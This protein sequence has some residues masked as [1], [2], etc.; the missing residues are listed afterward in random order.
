M[1]FTELMSSVA[2]EQAIAERDGIKKA[3]EE[4]IPFPFE[5]LEQ[6]LKS[7]VDFIYDNFIIPNRVRVTKDIVSKFEEDVINLD[8]RLRR[9]EKAITQREEGVITSWLRQNIL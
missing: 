2:R 1:N 7:I 5:I 8:S 9:L 6:H 4:I 3:I